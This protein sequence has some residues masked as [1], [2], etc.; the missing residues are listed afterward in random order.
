MALHVRICWLASGMHS[1]GEGDKM[2]AK[3]C[4]IKSWQRSIHNWRWKRAWT[5]AKRPCPRWKRSHSAIASKGYSGRS[6]TAQFAIGVVPFC[7]PILND[8]TPRE[9]ARQQV[10]ASRVGGLLNN[11]VEIC[12]GEGYFGRAGRLP[13]D[14]H[15]GVQV[16]YFLL[17]C[18]NPCLS[19]LIALP[20][21]AHRSQ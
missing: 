12:G 21:S 13:L 1:D 6:I 11:V 16:L 8:F 18:S 20:S 4:D 19:V 2:S 9:A 3:R 5:W 17:C 15:P 14:R 7:R 10:V